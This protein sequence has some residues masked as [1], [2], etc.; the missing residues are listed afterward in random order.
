M[1]LDSN[2]SFGPARGEVGQAPLRDEAGQSRPTSASYDVIVVGTGLAGGVGRGLAG[3]AGLQRQVLLLSRTARAARTA[4]PPRAASTRPRT[5][6]TTATASTACSTTRSRAATS[7]PARPTSTAWPQ[8]SVNIIDQC[9]AQGVPFAREYGGLLANR[10]FGGR[11]GL[12]HLLRPRPDRPAAAARRLPGARCGRSAPATVKM[13]P[14]HRDA[15]PGRWSTA[16]PRGIVTRN[17]VTGEIESPRRRRGRAGHRRLRQRLLSCRPTPRA[18]TSRAIWRAY[19]RGALFANP[20][21]TQIHPTCIPVRGDYQSQA[22]ADERVAAQR[23]PH[24][25][26]EEPAATSAPPAQIPEDERDYY[27]ERTL[28]ELRQP[29]PARRRLARGQGGLRRGA[30]RRAR[31]PRRLPR[32]RR[33]DRAAWAR[34]R[35]RERY[36]N[37]FEMYERI[38]GENPYEVPM[39]I[40]PAVHYTMGGLWVDYNLMSTVPGLFVLGEANFSDHGANRLGASALMQGLADGYF[41]IPYTDRRLPR[42][43]ATLA[44]VGTDHAAFDERRAARSRSDARQLLAIGGKRTV[45]SF[46]RELGQLMWEHC[47]MARNEAGLE[48]ALEKIP[49]LREE[50]WQ[51]VTRRR[52]AASELNQALEKAGRVADFL[53]LAEL[54]CRDALAARRVLRRPL[55]RGAPDRARARRSA[56]TRTSPTSRP[57]STTGD[58]KQPTLH[59]EPLEFEYVHLAHA[60]LQVDEDHE[61]DAPRLAAEERDRTQGRFVTYDARRRQPRHVVS[62]DARRRQRAAHRARA[63]SRSPSTTTAARASAAPAAW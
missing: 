22:H 17:L 51:N 3:R 49:A 23:R 20:C 59:K 16:R 21:F 6:R 47:G 13:Y 43:R 63:R 44:K 4:S 12:A 45:D 7:A 50:F 62:R 26:A 15:R 41:V 48:E 11:A 18:A 10:S 25:G 24:L 55:P 29:R 2:S 42:R 31:R 8:V 58:G 40:Y 56:T 37:L 32:L 46:H 33:R 61:A 39:R 54:M 53:E 35:S 9:V 27:L 5:T 30:R 28:P 14:A 38:T 36:G 60:E 34:T 52:A 1:T 57:G 19:R